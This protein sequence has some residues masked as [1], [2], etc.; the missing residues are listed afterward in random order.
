MKEYE[1]S[2]QITFIPVYPGM[3]SQQMPVGRGGGGEEGPPN[4]RDA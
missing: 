2:N 1:V 3:R 4:A